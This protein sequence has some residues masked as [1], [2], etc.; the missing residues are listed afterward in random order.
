MISYDRSIITRTNFSLLDLPESGFWVLFFFHER[1]KFHV[2]GKR[3]NAYFHSVETTSGKR[4][5]WRENYGH[6]VT[7]AV[8]V[9]RNFSIR[10]VSR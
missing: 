4:E 10:L 3:E 5:K 1:R 9:S 6:V 7:F 2:C 8:R